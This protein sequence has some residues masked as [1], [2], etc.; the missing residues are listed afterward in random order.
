M[1]SEAAEEVVY[2]IYATILENEGGTYFDYLSRKDEKFDLAGAF[3]WT[4][5]SQGFDY[6]RLI[7]TLLENN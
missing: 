7:N 2:S 4:Q 3:S 5:T 6:W 1:G